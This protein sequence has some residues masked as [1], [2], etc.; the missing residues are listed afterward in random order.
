MEFAGDSVP[1]VGYVLEDEA[2]PITSN[3][4]R[5]PA[6]VSGSF[7]ASPIRKHFQSISHHQV[8]MGFAA[9]HAVH[10]VDFTLIPHGNQTRGR[11]VGSAS[12]RD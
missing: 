2:V 1:G 8:S 10:S 11:P 12:S 5:Q 7:T 9:L 4:A 6:A 3:L